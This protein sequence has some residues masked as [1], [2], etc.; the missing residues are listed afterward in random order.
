MRGFAVSRICR[1]A[2]LCAEG[3]RVCHVEHLAC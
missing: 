3:L 1:I 2:G